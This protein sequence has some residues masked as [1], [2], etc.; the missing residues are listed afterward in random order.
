MMEEW[1][2]GFR[3]AYVSHAKA[4]MKMELPRKA[5][6]VEKVVERVLPGEL[7]GRIE[8]MAVRKGRPFGGCVEWEDVKGEQRAGRGEGD[9][10]RGEGEE[11]GE[12]EKRL[13]GAAAHWFLG[14][15]EI[16]EILAEEEGNL[17]VVNVW[18]LTANVGQQVEYHVD[19]AELHRL[20]TGIIHPPL[21]S[22]TVHVGDVELEGGEFMYNRNGLDHYRRYGY[23]G[24]LG[25]L[26]E[27]LKTDEWATIPYRFNRGI[28]I[29]GDFPHLSTKV[30]QIHPETGRRVI[31][32]FNVFDAEVREVCQRAPEHS[33][34]FNRIVKLYQ[35]VGNSESWKAK[36]GLRFDDVRKNKQLSK[37]L[38]S[39]ARKIKVKNG[40]VQ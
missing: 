18:C 31:L 30:T 16:G 3:P 29:D 40:V 15:G 1:E 26:E 12:Y 17:A 7:A 25:N 38:V 11:E 36:G 24:K 5:R 10:G 34:E 37:L 32:G 4:R 28:F 6:G 20:E 9:Y 21:Y 35:T 33:K 14:R 13:L 27:D 8:R 2:D 23:K 19:Y 39:L 22:G